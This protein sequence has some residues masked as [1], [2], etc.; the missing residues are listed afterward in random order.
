MSL[1]VSGVWEGGVWNPTVWAEGI[2]SEVAAIIVARTKGGGPSS[3][4]EFNKLEQKQLAH[5][6]KL[7]MIRHDDNEVLALILGELKL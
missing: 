5:L 7:Q 2:W 6:R 1:S 3:E 4:E